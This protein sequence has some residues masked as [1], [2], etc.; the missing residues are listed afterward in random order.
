MTVTIDAGSLNTEGLNK[1]PQNIDD[2]TITQL[3][4]KNSAGKTVGLAHYA[5]GKL[6]QVERYV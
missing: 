5:G 4:I 2:I 1:L 6:T 3:K